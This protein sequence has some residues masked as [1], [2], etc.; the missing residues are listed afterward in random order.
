MDPSPD[1]DRYTTSAHQ[2][3]LD[4]L[5][6][7]IA[8]HLMPVTA[9]GLGVALEWAI[10]ELAE[11][12]GVDTAFLRRHD[13][14]QGVSVLM[15]EWPRRDNVPDPDPLGVVPFDADP[16]FAA[17]RRLLEPLIVRPTE[18]PAYQ[19]RIGEASGL[20]QV[21]TVTVP[22]VHKDVTEGVL[23]FVNFE[24]RDWT[25]SE[26]NALRAIA[27]LLLQLQARIAAE[28][29]LQHNA[30]H[31]E[32][33]GLA[34]RRSILGLLEERLDPSSGTSVGVLSV[35]LD[36]MKVLNDA[37]GHRLGDR[38]LVA[39]ADRLD[40]STRRQDVVGRMGDDEFVV[41]LG[42]PV[43]EQ[44]ARRTAE[45]LLSVMSAPFDVE[46][47]PLT[48][49]CSIGVAFGHAGVL[50]GED[51]LAEADA[52]MYA[53]KHKGRNQA[54]VFDD[55]LRATVNRRFE[56]EQ[57]L[58]T[59]I[60]AGQLRLH[61]Q[62]EIDLASGELLALEA[63]LRWQHPK[64]GLMTAGAFIEVAEESGLVV[65]IGRWVL[66]EAARQAAQWLQ[67]RPD[68]VVRVNMSPAQLI[69]QDI[70]S[71]VRTTL[72]RHNV[73][74]RALCLEVTEHA[75]VQDMQL[76]AGVLQELRATGIHI[77]IDDFG[78]GYSSMT[79]LKHLPADT[80]KMDH[81]FVSGLG[82]DERD[83]A[84]VQATVALATRLGLDLVA[85]GV[86]ELHHAERLLALGCRRAQGYLLARPA[87]PADLEDVVL[88][89]R[90]LG[91]PR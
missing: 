78:T 83:E 31:D 5:V 56:M 7:R 37:L 14:E 60:K 39:V 21:A 29:Q 46:G 11:F 28:E 57:Q 73:P 69:I 67:H 17:S 80:L 32:L 15:A 10:Q 85:E 41:V 91:I 62:P 27:S 45:R 33:T 20:G 58:R 76:V 38:L 52:A 81:S 86:E 16:V 40:T 8:V 26:V 6:T 71:V 4:E 9:S 43:D 55:Q 49:T 77:A 87:A 51:L 2:H 79:Q 66:D 44:E 13:H 59:A 90:R 47:Q 36:H 35:D 50:S 61:Y 72:Q 34:N 30:F 88:G 89:H 23:G 75:V 84:I 24:G 12:F 48:R 65:E 82:R 19:G 53:A 74:S 1:E 42:D 64:Q 3:R 63:L 18:A 68:L 22:L 54:A 25:S 70:V